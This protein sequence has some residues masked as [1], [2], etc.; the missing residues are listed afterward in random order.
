MSG[1]ALSSCPQIDRRQHEYRYGS[2]CS[3][4]QVS[5][6]FIKAINVHILQTSRNS[7][8]IN[9]ILNSYVQPRILHI[10]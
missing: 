10:D 6:S 7:Q 9:T 5:L 4:C 2:V 1:K 3:C 8:A